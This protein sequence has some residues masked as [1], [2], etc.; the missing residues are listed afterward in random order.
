[1]AAH[2]YHVA[3]PGYV[4]RED[5]RED[6]DIRGPHDKIAATDA[7]QAD[8]LRQID[9]IVAEPEVTRR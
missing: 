2:D 4:E 8:L 7:R 6:I 3:V 1:V 5:T 9:V